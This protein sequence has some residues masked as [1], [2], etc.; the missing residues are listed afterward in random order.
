MNI[1]MIGMAGSGKGTQAKRIAKEFGLKHIGAGDVLR[2]EVAKGTELGKKIQKYQHEG[3]LV[4][5]DIVVNAM[6]ANMDDNNILDG[7]PRS[8]EQAEAL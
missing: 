8:L 2:A 4:P 5:V 6:K 3:E 1:V 7:F